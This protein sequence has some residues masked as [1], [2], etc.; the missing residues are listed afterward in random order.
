MARQKFLRTLPEGSV[1]A[2]AAE[3]TIHGAVPLAIHG[4][5]EIPAYAA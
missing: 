3:Q 2:Q 5:P 4:S 1:Q